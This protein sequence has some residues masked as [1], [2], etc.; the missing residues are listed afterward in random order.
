MSPIEEKAQKFK[1]FLSKTEIQVSIILAFCSLLFI[2][3]VGGWDLWNPDEPRYA[4]VAKEMVER[5]DW[6]LMHVN[7]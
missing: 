2:V 5:G 1:R 4:E 7:G 6:I 3:G